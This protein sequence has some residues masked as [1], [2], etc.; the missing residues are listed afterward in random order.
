MTCTEASFLLTSVTSK[1]T[2]TKTFHIFKSWHKPISLVKLHVVWQYR[3]VLFSG[4]PISFYS[5]LQTWRMRGLKRYP[6]TMRGMLPHVSSPKPIK[7]APSVPFTDPAKNHPAWLPSFH[8]IYTFYIWPAL[9]WNWDTLF[10]LK[11]KMLLNQLFL[12]KVYCLKCCSI[13]LNKM[14]Y[15]CQN[16]SNSA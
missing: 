8:S 1:M 4:H 14:E 10:Y 9:R 11:R 6:K 15:N 5:L 16:Y 12:L 13:Y 7:H 2:K 3:C